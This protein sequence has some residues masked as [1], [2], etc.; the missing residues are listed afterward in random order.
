MQKIIILFVF[1]A[2]QKGRCA[3]P[4]KEELDG[5]QID[6]FRRQISCPAAHH[7]TERNWNVVQN[8]LSPKEEIESCFF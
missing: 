1:E 4:S 8:Q 3:V 2:Q 6:A 5:T 7:G